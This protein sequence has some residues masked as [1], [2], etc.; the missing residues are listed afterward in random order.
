MLPTAT[1]EAVYPAVT[2]GWIE[3]R[4]DGSI[5]RIAQRR[6]NRWNDRVVTRAVTPHR[7]DAIVSTGYRHVNVTIDRE[8]VGTLAH[9]LVWRHFK[10]PIPAG[11]TINHKNGRKGDNR[12]RNLETATYSE[13]MTH[14][15]RT[16]LKDEHGEK[17]PAAKLTNATV[18]TIRRIYAR[19]GTTQAA[20]ARR[21]G[22]RFQQISR[23][24]RG[25]R[26]PRQAGP[27][28]DY[29]TRRQHPIVRDSAGRFRSFR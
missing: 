21:H 11:L 9:R 1:E 12:P 2:A 8:Q 16:G 10:G 25:D 6:R 5:W 22:V 29:T 15:Y 26:R 23:I 14:A 24:V 27:T 19:G 17:N 18:A 4:S 3:I 28:A 20:L 7:I 13:Q